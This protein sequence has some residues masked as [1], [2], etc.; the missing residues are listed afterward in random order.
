MITTILFDIGDTL[1]HAD[2]PGTPVE[3]LAVRP[4]DGAVRS[5]RALARRYRLGA[6]T[7]TAVM[8]GDQ[9][10]AALRGTGL[11]DLLEVIV[12]SVDVGAA[13][14]DSRG[15][16][17]ALAHLGT[18][19]GEA[20]F[21]GDAA[22]D[23]QAA[24]AA[25]VGFERTGPDRDPGGAVRVALTEEIGAYTAAI[26]LVGPVDHAAADGARA[27]HDRLTKPRGSLG[28]LETLGVQLAA[29]S[30]SDPPPIPD[31]AAVAVFAADHGVVAA[32]VTPWPQEVTGQMVANFVG[33]G[34]AINV[35]ARQAG[36]TVTVVDVGVATD[37]DSLGLA[38]APG[39]LRRRIRPGTANLA[40]GPAMSHREARAARDVGAE[41]AADLV[42][43]G[44]AVLVTGDMGIG[45][46]T[47]AAAV[48]AAF[49]GRPAS[50]VTGRGTGVDDEALRRKIAIV[51]RAVNRLPSNAQGHAVLAEVGGLEIAALAGFILGAAAQR[52]PVVVDGVIACAALLAAHADCPEM[53]PYVIVGH[54][55][56]EPGATAVLDH[57][58]SEPVLDLELRLGEGTGAC[59]ALNIVEASARI[60][61]EMATFDA[62]GVSD[63]H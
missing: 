52:V 2:P 15:I 25:G 8:T 12:T 1:V 55:S 51:E 42:A 30:G 19:P 11:E 23:E 46:T 13:K 3:E 34:A 4:V 53:L 26:A 5:L 50:A 24:R 20:L 63:K 16:R 47:A 48:I 17:R 60:L 57:L 32:G 28:R 59:L 29:I 45:N 58:G 39:L 33:G 35:L 62:A 21:V 61:R 38:D 37:L 22:V 41:V 27:H 7:D 40:T 36:A 31:P 44:A 54:R 43:R 10:R 18:Q 49:T 56:T 9:V 6:V 14:P